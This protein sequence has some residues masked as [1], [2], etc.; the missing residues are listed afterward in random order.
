ML[1]E[2]LLSEPEPDGRRVRGLCGVDFDP[3]VDGDACPC[4][5][6]IVDVTKST[7]GTAASTTMSAE[8][9]APPTAMLPSP[10]V[11]LPPQGVGFNANPLNPVD[12]YKVLAGG[13]F[14]GQHWRLVRDT[15]VAPDN[16]QPAP[17][18]TG[19]L[20]MSHS[21][22]VGT[23]TCDFTGLQWGDRAPG[24]LPDFDAGGRCGQPARGGGGIEQ[25][26][27][28][29]M[30]GMANRVPTSEMPVSWF[31]GQVDASKVASVTFTI[32]GRTT[33]RQPIIAVPGES[34]G[35]YVVFVPPLTFQDE[36]SVYLTGY[37][38]SGHV[39]AR[40]DESTQ[41]PVAH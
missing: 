8:Q 38:A 35:Y 19:H 40:L 22:Q 39:V 13:S 34:D 37:D 36:A 2:E 29:L 18:S 32:G 28:P 24:T 25:I 33:T 26:T 30:G 21:G 31:I 20:P 23:S 6:R 3:G 5:A 17:Q 12:D 15:F 9:F 16:S 10:T 7:T 11:T 14:G 4:V 1:L 41:Q 27:G